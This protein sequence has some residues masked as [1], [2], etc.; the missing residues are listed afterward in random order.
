MRTFHTISKV[1]NSCRRNRHP[2]NKPNLAMYAAKKGNRKPDY[3]NRIFIDQH[4]RGNY[5][6]GRG[7]KFDGKK[8][9]I[10]RHSG[11]YGFI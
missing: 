1:D 4:I 3:E 5:I 8:L 7:I 9:I 11:H 2:L 10:S 6:V